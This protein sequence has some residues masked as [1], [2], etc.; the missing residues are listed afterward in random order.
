MCRGSSV[1]SEEGEAADDSDLDDVEPNEDHPTSI[2]DNLDLK[3]APKSATPK[4]EDEAEMAVRVK[5]SKRSASDSGSRSSSLSQDSDGDPPSDH[6]IDYDQK[7]VNTFKAENTVDFA[8]RCE[9]KSEL[10][11]SPGNHLSF[12]Y[13][14]N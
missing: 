4:D 10:A 3:V 14:S 9:F 12:I 2:K 5:R 13:A 6:D 8:F 1:H 11:L 7:L